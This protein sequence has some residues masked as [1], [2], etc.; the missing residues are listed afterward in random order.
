MNS[1]AAQTYQGEKGES[2]RRKTR[3]PE[4]RLQIDVPN[5]SNVRSTR[6]CGAMRGYE[7][8]RAVKWRKICCASRVLSA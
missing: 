7:S 4:Q 1:R 3:R 2:R 6:E 8:V 5:P